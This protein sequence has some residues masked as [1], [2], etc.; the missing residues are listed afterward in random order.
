[1][2]DTEAT[3]PTV[4]ATEQAGSGAAAEEAENDPHFEPVIK[5]ENQVEVKTH[6]ED[7]SVTFKMRA[8]LFRFDKEAKE[9]KERGTGDVRL[10]EHKQTHKVRLVMRRDKTL[11]VCANH[12]VTSDMKLSPNV[13]SDR[14]W[15]YN[16]AAD[17]ADGEPTAETL[18]IRFANSDNA[19]AFKDA[20]EAAQKSNAASKSDAP[21]TAAADDD[22]K[23]AA[24][25]AAKGDDKKD[26]DKKDE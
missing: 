26:D 13:G 20:F 12:Y 23:D 5:L 2:A 9:W 19:N 10:L 3:K 7:E 4:D 11:K 17:V 18:A 21:P 16:V 25:E 8:K 6:E 14:S 15:V 1:M 22:K 24:P